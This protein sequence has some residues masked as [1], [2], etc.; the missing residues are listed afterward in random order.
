MELGLTSAVGPT[1]PGTALVVGLPTYARS[2]RF[3]L[4]YLLTV[5]AHINPSTCTV[6][7]NRPEILVLVEAVCGRCGEFASLTHNDFLTSIGAGLHDQI[8]S[9]DGGGEKD[10]RL[11]TA[12]QIR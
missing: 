12:K 6:V 9:W 3:I 11:K 5:P 8:D 2:R 1:C 10:S 7:E 4:A